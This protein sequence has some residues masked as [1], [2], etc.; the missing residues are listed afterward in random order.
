MLRNVSPFVHTSAED[1]KD[2]F[3]LTRKARQIMTT[4]VVTVESKLGI[5]DACELLLQKKVGLLPVVDGDKLVGVV[6]WRDI[7][8]YFIQ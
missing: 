8:S 4:D 1:K 7:L 6:S 2:S 3:T 5:R